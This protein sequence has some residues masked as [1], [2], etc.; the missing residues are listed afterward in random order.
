MSNQT[1]ATLRLL[2]LVVLLGAALWPRAGRDGRTPQGS[3]MAEERLSAS[4]AIARNP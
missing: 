4:A 3:R 2:A 1:H